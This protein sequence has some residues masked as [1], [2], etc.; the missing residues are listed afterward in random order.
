[1]LSSCKRD[2]Y[3]TFGDLRMAFSEVKVAQSV[4]DSGAFTVTKGKAQ[5][6]FTPDSKPMDHI[7]GFRVEVSNMAGSGLTTEK[8]LIDLILAKMKTKPEEIFN[9]V[10]PSLTHSEFPHEEAKDLRSFFEYFCDSRPHSGYSAAEVRSVLP[11]IYRDEFDRQAQGN[12][13]EIILDWPHD[14]RDLSMTFC[15]DS[16]Q[17]AVLLGSFGLGYHKAEP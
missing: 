8:E 4:V 12:K 13:F 10:L 17:Q 11:A 5:F 15:E 1:M 9:I 3:G 7:V 6:R 14:A 2:V 16:A